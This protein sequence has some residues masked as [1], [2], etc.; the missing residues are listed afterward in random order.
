MKKAALLALACASLFA[1]SQATAQEVTYV[2]DCSQG[3][4]IN[5]MKS[6]WF[7]TAQGGANTLF[8]N[9]DTEASWGQRIG[10]S[11]NIY[12]GKWF[13][14]V[15]GFRF[16]VSGNINRGAT[17]PEGYFR[18]PHF[19]PISQHDG[20][21][22]YPERLATLGPKIEL[23][24][25]VTNWLCGYNPNRLYNGV[26]HLGGGGYW[27]FKHTEADHAW[28]N[29]HNRTLYGSLG[30]TNNFNV[31]K[32][33][34][35]FLDLEAT[36]MDYQTNEE[37]N[38]GKAGQNMSCS[39]A[40][41]VGVTYKFSKTDWNCPTTAVCPTWKYTDAEGDAL[42]ARLASADN[43]IRDL[44]RQLDDCLNRP[45]KDC[46]NALATIYYPINVSTLSNREVT[47]VQ[48]M[49]KTIKA[50]PDK[51]YIL[52]GWADNYTGNDQ[53]NT[54]LRNQRVD[55]VYNCLVKAGVPES[56]L[57]KRIDANN[58]TDYGI[59]GAQFDRAVTIIEAN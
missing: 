12:F 8:T 37:A 49:A 58:L 1:T 51:K 56:Q 40:A 52:T 28:H 41:Q 11:A 57:E 34:D 7:I 4:L 59:K 29:A 43:K 6:N 32:H 33:F 19:G 54:R 38:R 39:L 36:V 21:T 24:F 35:I 22:W 45:D 9:H 14:P 55:G 26:I 18:D 46:V 48:S 25:S 53:I 27:T 13:T 20:M 47:L 17:T 2:E 44:Q 23:M 5:P 42:T 3:L 15:W 50:N 30:Y 10:A 16:G 31:S